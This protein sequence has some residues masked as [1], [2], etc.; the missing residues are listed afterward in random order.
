M[1]WGSLSS[2]RLQTLMLR[3]EQACAR[4]PVAEPR[5]GQSK[6][7]HWEE[8]LLGSDYMTRAL[9]TSEEGSRRDWC[10]LTGRGCAGRR[11]V[12]P[13][14]MVKVLETPRKCQVGHGEGVRQSASR[15]RGHR[16]SGVSPL[17]SASLKKVRQGAEPEGAGRLA[18][19]EPRHSQW[20]P[21]GDRDAAFPD[22]GHH[23]WVAIWGPHSSSWCCLVFLTCWSHFR[24]P[25]SQR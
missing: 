19:Q 11:G 21:N 24:G 3:R 13:L 20:E 22:V 17:S 25:H 10:G 7:P 23:H 6:G 2:P 1:T 8:C 9:S 15:A 12:C 4:H 16:V 14:L 18:T 5:A